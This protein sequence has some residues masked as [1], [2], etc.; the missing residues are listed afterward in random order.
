MPTLMP[1]SVFR[2][3]GESHCQMFFVS[4]VRELKKHIAKQVNTFSLFFLVIILF[5]Y[6]SV[7]FSEKLLGHSS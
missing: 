1:V 6:F 4:C 7:C 2:Q 5:V 3:Y